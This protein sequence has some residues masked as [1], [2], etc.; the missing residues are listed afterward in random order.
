MLAMMEYEKGCPERIQHFLKVHILA[1][2]IGLIEEIN[3]NDQYILEAAALVHDIGIRPSIV[4][5]HSSKGSYQEELGP[6][7]AKEMLLN[8]GYDNEVAQ[9]VAYLVSRHHTYTNIDGIDYQILV[10]ADFLVNMLEEEMSFESKKKVFDNI[11]Q[12]ASGKRLCR[13]MYSL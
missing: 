10:E 11:F 12:T 1:K 9:R 7:L 13:T 2:T 8:L 4:K 3:A 5:Y 6:P